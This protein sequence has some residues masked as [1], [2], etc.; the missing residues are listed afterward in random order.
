[1]AQPPIRATIATTLNHLNIIDLLYIFSSLIL[2]KGL[3]TTL[4]NL[5]LVY[6]FQEDYKQAEKLYRKAI[7]MIKHLLGNEHPNLI[8]VLNNLAYLL[9]YQG[10]DTEAKS[11]YQEA[12]EIAKKRLGYEHPKTIKIQ[13][14]LKDLEI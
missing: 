13:N 6:E 3:G 10:C 7:E 4:T 14:H 11:L 12:F 5:A 2:Y 9:N 1:M 8:T